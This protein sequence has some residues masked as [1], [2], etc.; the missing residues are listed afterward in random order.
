MD[1]LKHNR[2]AVEP[3]MPSENASTGDLN[4]SATDNRRGPEN[5]RKYPLCHYY[6]RT[7]IVLLIPP[8]LTTYF[9][10]I[11]LRYLQKGDDPVKYGA[12]GEVWI[13]YSWFVIGVFGLG[14]SKHGL[15][16]VEMAMLQSP[17][18]RARETRTLIMHSDSSWAG[19][20]GWVE[21][22]G[23]YL[24][25]RRGHVSGLWYLLSFLS[26]LPFIALPISGLCLEL[27]DGYVSA[28]THPSVIG[29]T[30]TDFNSRQSGQTILRGQLRW[31]TGSSGEVPG[32]GLV[33][34]PPYVQRSQINGLDSLP[35]K[36]PANGSVPEI[37]LVPQASV[38]ISG[39]AWGLRLGYNC[40]IVEDASEFTILSQKSMSN[41]TG[42]ISSYQY[43]PIS[44]KAP[45]GTIY[46]Y[47]SSATSG[48]EGNL[49]AY[50]EMGMSNITHVKYDGSEPAS[51]DPQ[52]ISS[53]A[54][55]L[56]FAI[57]QVRKKAAYN[58]DEK[59]GS[60]FNES[61]NHSI[62][63]IGQPLVLGANGIYERNSTFF[64][65]ANVTDN[66]LEPFVSPERMT[67]KHLA[68]PIGLRCTRMSTL[69]YAELDA[70]TN[71]FRSFTRSSPPPFN[72]NEEEDAAPRF[73]YTARYILQ[74]QYLN[75]WSS[76]NSATPK[77]FSNSVYYG[78]FLQA[79]ELQQSVML[80]H[81]MDAIQLMYDGVTSFQSAY[82]NSNL[83]SSKKGKVLTLGVVPPI[84]PAVLFL[85][86][87]AGCVTLG[88]GFGFGRRWSDTL[89][90]YSLFR[91]GVNLADT[92]GDD[93]DLPDKGD[94][95]RCTALSTLPDPLS[96]S[97]TAKAQ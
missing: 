12:T 49:Y 47:N 41:V 84:A 44:L 20:E 1:L 8:L 68:P 62:K 83:T 58:A 73:G 28:P 76:I 31:E 56:E 69:G 42:K 24:R 13:Y 33:Y 7:L 72:I 14:W 65:V 5:S 87:A 52:D 89:D 66:A 50:V 21:V 96:S 29:R 97:V 71:T 10:V 53:E 18:F 23:Q 35:N 26:L 9:L 77:T 94:L 48:Y 57:W 70:Q 38:P 22:L 60:S 95:G 19:P 92:I 39:H 78:A 4:A 54:D 16:G 74:G 75:F 27:S 6:A 51:F 93:A 40:T 11:W 59:D 88:L 55:I 85:V 32:I 36:M 37:F 82:E 25:G 34:T 43:S 3:L 2:N 15:S 67:I 30:W 61:L 90:G 64:R 79:A 86:W 80:A 81:A 91:F 17:F 63:N 46:V 45:S